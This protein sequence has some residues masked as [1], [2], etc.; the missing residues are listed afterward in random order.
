MAVVQ[1]TELR[2]LKYCVHKFAESRVDV[3]GIPRHTLTTTN[4]KSIRIEVANWVEQTYPG[5]FEIHLLGTNPEWLGEVA[6][7]RKYAD[8]VRSVD[9]SLPFN[10]AIARKSLRDCRDVVHRPDYYFEEDW[11]RRVDVRLLQDNITTFME[12]ADAEPR[13]PTPVSPVRNVSA[14]Q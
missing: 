2:M 14:A 13:T 4:N 1:G 10:Y 8:H 3:L 6:A 11:S 12:W 5:R 9:S 7:V